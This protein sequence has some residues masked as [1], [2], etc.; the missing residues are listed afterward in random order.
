M[1]ENQ[2]DAD[3]GFFEEMPTKSETEG[4]FPAHIALAMCYV[5]NQPFEDLYDDSKALERGTLFA[6]LDLPFYGGKRWKK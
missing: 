2:F 6:N 1:V 5:P 3:R 4:M